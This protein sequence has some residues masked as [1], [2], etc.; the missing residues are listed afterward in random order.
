M[1]TENHRKESLSIAYV[2]AVAAKAGATCDHSHLDYGVD[3]KINEVV[4]TRDGLEATGVSIE[5]QLK[6]SSTGWKDEGDYIRFDLQAKTYKTFVNRNTRQRR[7]TSLLLLVLCLPADENLWL[8]NNHD[9][10]ILKECCYWYNIVDVQVPDNNSSKRIRI[11]KHQIFT[12]QAL[13]SLLEIA[14]EGGILC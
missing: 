6:A 9:S 2:Y 14:G 5:F 13:T 7:S 3:C 1:I 12:P 8:F 4:N 10:L 11:P